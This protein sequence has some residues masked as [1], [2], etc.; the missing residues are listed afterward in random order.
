MAFD[1]PDAV[2]ACTRR[3]RSNTP[4]QSLMTL[5]EPVFL[6]CARALALRTLAEGG[7]TEAERLVF[8]F[9]RC[10]ARKPRTEEAAVLL[11]LLRFSRSMMP[12]AVLCVP[13]VDGAGAV[14]RNPP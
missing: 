1:A 4:L 6:E 3:N 7:Q 12:G 5:N 10:L 9:R 14:V 13:L 2:L 8:A 11:G